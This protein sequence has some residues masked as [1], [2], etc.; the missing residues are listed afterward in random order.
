M[1]SAGRSQNVRDARGLRDAVAEPCL[2][3][4]KKKQKP[5]AH[6]HPRLLVTHSTPLRFLL[7]LLIPIH[8][9]NPPDHI[10]Q[11]CRIGT[12]LS[13][14]MRTNCLWELEQCVK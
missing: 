14:K 3:S 11:I 12:E 7:L 6:E 8:Y 1:G 5:D 2:Q 4:S 9:F 10:K 13:F